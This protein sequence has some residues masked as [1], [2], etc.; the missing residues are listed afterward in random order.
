MGKKLAI[1]VVGNSGLNAGV[2]FMRLDLMRN[3]NFVDAIVKV[4]DGYKDILPGAE[5][6]MLNIIFSKNMGK[7]IK[8]NISYSIICF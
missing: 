8:V 5:Q 1:P 7:P 4:A 6:D 2:L 3:S